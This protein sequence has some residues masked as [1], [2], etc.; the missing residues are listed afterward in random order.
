MRAYLLLAAFLPGVTLGCSGGPGSYYADALV[1]APVRATDSL[2]DLVFTR[3][4][5]LGL[6]VYEAH[7]AVARL[8][9]L[10][11]DVYTTTDFLYAERQSGCGLNCKKVDALL[12]SFT[13]DA[14]TSGQRLKVTALTC[15]RGWV[16]PWRLV[17]PSDDIRRAADSLASTFRS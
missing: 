16:A 6:R 3:V 10:N 1:P 9:E 8:A 12:V 4:R 15:K 17:H 13:P 5:G 14:T 2:R 7:E 11:V